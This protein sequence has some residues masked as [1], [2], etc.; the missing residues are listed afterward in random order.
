MV[1]G[2]FA[3]KALAEELKLEKAMFAGGCFWCMEPPFEGRKGVAD[4][5]SGFSGGTEPNPTYE[6]VASGKTSHKEVV[7]ISFDPKQI[8]YDTLLE[9]FWRQ[10]DPTDDGGQFV[11]RG[12]MYSNAI[13]FT[14]KEQEEAAKKSKAK[15][16]ASK[17]FSKPIV[18]P[19]VAAGPFYRAEASHQDYYKKNSLKY[20]YYRWNS[21]RDQY[22]DQVWGGNRQTELNDR[23]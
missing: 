8:S 1:L 13:Y 4:V 11:D 17:K 23:F 12:P 7:E 9:I 6:D 16:D 14:T 19:I 5:V 10:V 18:T 20:K 21:G 2:S 22:L 15:M 3:A